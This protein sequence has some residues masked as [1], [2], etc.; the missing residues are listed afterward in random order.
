MIATFSLEMKK[1]WLC[2]LVFA[3][4]S[5]MHAQSPYPNFDFET[6]TLAGWTGQTGSCCPVFM[7]NAGFLSTRHAVMSGNGTDP[8]SNG[9]LPV[10]SPGG[11]YSLR[12]GNDS[13]HSEAE[14]VS[15]E[16]LV[17][18]AAPLVVV[19]YAVVLEYPSGH[20]PAKQPRF[21]LT[22]R[23][24]TGMALPC[25]S[26]NVISASQIPGF[27]PVGDYRIKPWS[28]ITL[29]LRPY[30]GKRVVIDIATG[31]CGMGGHFGYAYV[32]GYATAAAIA[33]EGCNPDG[34]VTL[35]AP[36]GFGYA[37]STGHTTQQVTLSHYNGGQ[38]IGVSL[39][40]HTG[41]FTQLDTLLPSFLPTASF[42]HA[43]RCDLGVDFT[44]LST[45]GSPV[46]N[47]KWEFGDAHLS[48][49]VNPTHQY[50]QPGTYPVTLTVHSGYCRSSKTINVPVEMAVRAGF[51]TDPGMICTGLPVQFH[52]L[53]TASR[54]VISSWYWEFGDFSQSGSRDPSHVYLHSGEYP[55]SLFVTTDESC[56][57]RAEMAVRVY[58]GDSCVSPGGQVYIPNSFTPN[59]D[60][61]NDHFMAVAQDAEITAFEIRDRWGRMVY[62][63]NGSAAR[64]DGRLR[65]G[66]SAPDGVYTYLIAARLTDGTLRQISGFVLLLH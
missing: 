8:Y 55:V 51:K 24:T 28:D 3:C 41:C 53:S 39:H 49:A 34:T 57:D 12:L 38:A 42:S 23:D 65:N 16:L 11:N 15:Y 63:G 14:R 54:G 25:G 44:D 10:V 50:M 33:T 59:G 45:S 26:Y 1:V 52:D 5:V 37:W 9:M 22:V 7:Q 30:A 66:R 64:W 6:G 19:Q 61:L 17:D 35:T 56:T 2:T 32:D 31:D 29:D 58:E 4:N 40:S 60:G 36:P 47:R 21:E 27:I 48:T 62:E 20:P 46:S 18:A 43:P 13:I